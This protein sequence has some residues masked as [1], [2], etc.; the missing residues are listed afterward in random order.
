M[1][2]GP[3]E[4]AAAE[5]ATIPELIPQKPRRTSTEA[6]RRASFPNRGSPPK[7]SSWLSQFFVKGRPLSEADRI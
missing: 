2:K 1:P 4:N 3:R 7:S 5:Q 6:D